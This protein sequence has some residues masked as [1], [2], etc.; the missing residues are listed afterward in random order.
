MPNQDTMD[1]IKAVLKLQGCLISVIFAFL[2]MCTNFFDEPNCN[3]NNC[4]EKEVLHE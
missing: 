4:K 2:W 1:L 3:C